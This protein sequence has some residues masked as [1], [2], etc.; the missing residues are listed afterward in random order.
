MTVCDQN[1]RQATG[2]GETPLNVQWAWPSNLPYRDRLELMRQLC[3]QIAESWVRCEAAG[4]PIELGYAFQLKVLPHLLRRA[5]AITSREDMPHLAA[6][7]AAS[8]FDIALHDAYGVLHRM[9]SYLTYTQHFMNHDLAAYMQADADVDENFADKYPSDFLSKS[10]STSLPVWH[11]VGGL[12]AITSEDRYGDLPPADNYPTV[13]TDWIRSDGLTCLKIKLVGNN[14]DWD[15]H[16]LVRVGKVAAAAGVKC[17][18]ADFNCTVDHPD[19]VNQILDRLSQQ[20]PDLYEMILYLEQPFPYDL[21]SNP[22]DVRSISRR[23]LL[24]L[25]ESADDWRS[26]QL[27]RSLGWTG[28]ALKTCK[29]QT[30]A[31]LALCWAKAHGM[32]VMVQ[33]LTNPMLA[34]IPHVRLAAHADTLM[35]VEANASQFYPDAS[36]YEAEVHPGLY[37]R[38][39]GVLDLSTI[40]GP[41][42]GYRLDE[43]RRE[44]PA[45]FAVFE[46][47]SSYRVD[48]REEDLTAP[49]FA[50]VFQRKGTAKGARATVKST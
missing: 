8:A 3:I 15:Y 36:T 21:E 13:L 6:L 50:S 19:Y 11:M 41:G 22:I 39:N 34:H 47:G 10:A 26:V 7:V 20:H 37:R 42:F 45:P 44:L 27:G 29:S 4:H 31:L 38:R 17:L 46:R 35:G 18:S 1:G 40:K 14:P 33:D 16:R 2:W 12:D 23:K 32:P 30:G 5:N 9:D 28:V 24:F 43:M 49:V 25:D 48:S